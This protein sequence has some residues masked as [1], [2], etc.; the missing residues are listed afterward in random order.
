LENKDQ[1]EHGSADGDVK[2]ITEQEFCRQVGISVSTALALRK[3]GKLGHCRVGRRV[4][5]IYPR[6]VEEFLARTERKPKAA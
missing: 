3:A 2:T 6:H 5:Y 4:L 1:S